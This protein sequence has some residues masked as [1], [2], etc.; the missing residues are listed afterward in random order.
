M[1]KTVRVLANVP[2]RVKVRPDSLRQTLTVVD[3]VAIAPADETAEA[4]PIT[5]GEDSCGSEE[6]C[7]VKLP[8]TLVLE[9]RV[10][11]D[12]RVRDIVCGNPTDC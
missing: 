5:G 4:L 11:A 8:V 9:V 6:C 7:Y 1:D 2:V 12:C 10:R 3:E